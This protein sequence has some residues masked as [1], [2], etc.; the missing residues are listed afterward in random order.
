MIHYKT[1]C[2]TRFSK[3]KKSAIKTSRYAKQ[4]FPSD[5]FEDIFSIGWSNILSP[6]IRAGIDPENAI[7]DSALIIATGSCRY[8]SVFV[9]DESAVDFAESAPLGDADARSIAE[10]II[11][12]S[13]PVGADGR[14]CIHPIWFHLPGRANSIFVAVLVKNS[15]PYVIVGGDGSNYFSVKVDDN[16][17]GMAIASETNSARIALNLCMMM[18]AFPEW[19][20]DGAPNL[21]KAY[22][23]PSKCIAPDKAFI[24][25][26][27]KA[28]ATPHMRRGHFRFLHSERYT[29]SRGQI[30]FVRP[31]MVKGRA[32]TV[33]AEL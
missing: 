26:Q 7:A 24:D 20:S 15:E 2:G 31:T 33:E 25:I 21:T 8:M 30:V 17:G 29:K 18:A 19:V 4:G 10:S 11:N 32:K 3:I 1:N 28:D 16:Q 6:M 22:G 12:E 5:G 13:S 23:H 14:N 9:S 27:K